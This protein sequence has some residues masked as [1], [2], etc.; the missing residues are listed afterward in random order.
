MKRILAFALCVLTLFALVSCSAGNK[1]G[2]VKKPATQV[3]EL[4]KNLLNNVETDKIE[5]DVKPLAEK[6][7]EIVAECAKKFGFENINLF[8]A[9]A[10]AIGVE[11]ENITQN[12]IDKVHYIAVGPEG[13]D[14]YTVY[15]GYVDYVDICFSDIE[16]DK[17]MS[18]LNEV[19]MISEFVYDEENDTMEDL[20]KFKNV[21]IFEIY[22]VKVS[23]VSFVK[24]YN[25]LVLG[26]FNT[27]GITD[28]SA[29][30]GYNP[31]S[32]AEL[33]FTG[34]SISDWS[35]LYH[36]KE[37]VI[38]FYGVADGMPVTITL[39]NKL[40]QDKENE[41]AVAVPEVKEE[42]SEEINEEPEAEEK[43]P[44][45]VDENGEAV[46]FGSLFD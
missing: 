8:E 39:K 14:M 44:A 5:I 30:E 27:N 6:D 7:K 19:V 42:A 3:V 18:A 28:I 36:I 34:N 10:N 40:E 35:P 11:P 16:E 4:D 17:I 21:E 2:G 23:D 38:V 32:L 20:A 33:D 46:D 1:E 43:K 41:E 45:L 24:A 37:K 15:I 12:D 13:E 22:D 29:L 9:F 25:D 31:E 26:Y